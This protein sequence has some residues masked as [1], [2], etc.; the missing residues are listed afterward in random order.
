MYLWL[1]NFILKPFETLLF[2]GLI[3]RHCGF[4]LFTFEI[5]LQLL[6]GR[7]YKKEIILS[8]EFHF[9]SVLKLIKKMTVSSVN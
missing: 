8:E 4:S 1:V 9:N 5:A 7:E 2:A 6:E 3:S